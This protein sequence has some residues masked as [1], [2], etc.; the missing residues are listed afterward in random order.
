M[1]VSGEQ[2]SSA[3]DIEFSNRIGP[4]YSLKH[5]T[6][7]NRNQYRDRNQRKQIIQNRFENLKFNL[8][9]EKLSF[10]Y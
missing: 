3:N 10:Q 8:N 4:Y 5:T 9:N 7:Y 1:S 2:F 6:T